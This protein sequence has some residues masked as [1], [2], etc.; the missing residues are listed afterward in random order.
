MA[1]VGLARLRPDPHGRRGGRG[2]DAALFSIL[3]IALALGLRSQLL[4]R[5]LWQVTVSA[6]A[7]AGVA[8]V[9]Y[10]TAA[11]QAW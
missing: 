9:F 2:T 5:G 1:P 8:A 6:I 3:G 11:T 10:L 4:R 7:L